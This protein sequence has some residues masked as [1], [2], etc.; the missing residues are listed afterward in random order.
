MPTQLRTGGRTRKDDR[1]LTGFGRSADM[2]SMHW[3]PFAAARC[4]LSQLAIV[5]ALSTSACSDS[6]GHGV[7]AKGTGGVHGAKSA[8]GASGESGE[9]GTGGASGAGG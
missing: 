5:V 6:S 7:S 4:W 3:N 9:S 2:M 1:R 8:G